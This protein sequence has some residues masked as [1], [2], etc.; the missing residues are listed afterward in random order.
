MRPSDVIAKRRGRAPRIRK[1]DLGEL[2]RLRI[3]M[4]EL[5]RSEQRDPERTVGRALY[6][7]GQRSRRRDVVQ[8]HLALFQDSA[9]RTCWTAAR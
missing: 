6:A 5:V 4:S 2:R 3:E 1:V 7:V 9:F 8:L